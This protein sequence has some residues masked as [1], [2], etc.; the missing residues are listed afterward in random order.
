MEWLPSTLHGISSAGPH[1]QI[2][3]YAGTVQ[4]CSRCSVQGR[5]HSTPSGFWCLQPEMVTQIRERFGKMHIAD[6][7]SPCQSWP[8]S[9]DRMCWTI[10]GLEIS[11]MFGLLPLILPLPPLGCR[12]LLLASIFGKTLD[13]TTVFLLPWQITPQPD[14]LSPLDGEIWMC[15]WV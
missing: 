4:W 9:W 13:S 6:Y 10:T 8:S 12:V 7:G 3:S 11:Y 1:P 15:Q 14:L 5:I 2:H